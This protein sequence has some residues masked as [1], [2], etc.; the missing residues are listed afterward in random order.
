M[1]T[2]GYKAISKQKNTENKIVR[3]NWF[4]RRHATRDLFILARKCWSNMIVLDSNGKRVKARDTADARRKND[5][6]RKSPLAFLRLSYLVCIWYLVMPC[7]E[8]KLF[9]AR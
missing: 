5:G 1:W 8:S 2:R 6:K 7:Y 3:G 4:I 9:E